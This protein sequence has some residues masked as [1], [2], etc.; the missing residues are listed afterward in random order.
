MTMELNSKMSYILDEKTNEE[1]IKKMLRMNIIEMSQYAD[2]V[3][4]K[5]F[6][7]N[8]FLQRQLPPDSIDSF[9]KEIKQNPNISYNPTI[10]GNL[11]WITAYSPEPYTTRAKKILDMILSHHK[12]KIIISKTENNYHCNIL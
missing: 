7:D 2:K 12:K 10:I 4:K 9:F 3:M 6:F 1:T 5:S 11:A 8:D